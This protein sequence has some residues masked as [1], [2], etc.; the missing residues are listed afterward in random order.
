M[1]C[2]LKTWQ[3]YSPKPKYPTQGLR[4][5][6]APKEFE[7]E[8]SELKKNWDKKPVNA[9]QV[10]NRYNDRDRDSDD[11]RDVR[12]EYEP[13]NGNAIAK[14]NTRLNEE[15]INRNRV[16]NYN[17][18]QDSYERLPVR[19]ADSW[20]ELPERDPSGRPANEGEEDYDD[21][22][23]AE[24][25]TLRPVKVPAVV[26]HVYG[27]PPPLESGKPT[28]PPRYLKAMS[29][30]PSTSGSIASPEKYTREVYENSRD[31]YQGRL[32]SGNIPTLRELLPTPDD[33]G[34]TYKTEPMVNHKYVN[35]GD[36]YRKATSE[37]AEPEEEPLPVD[38]NDGPLAGYAKDQYDKQL[39]ST[40]TK[41][42]ASSKNRSPMNIG[43]LSGG[44]ESAQ[45]IQPIKPA[46]RPIS[47]YFSSSPSNGQNSQ[48]SK[49]SIPYTS[50]SQTS[51]QTQSKIPESVLPPLS[52]SSVRSSSVPSS[53]S[54]SSEY[55]SP[56]RGDQQVVPLQPGQVPLLP[57][58]SR[59]PVSLD[60]GFDSG[61]RPLSAYSVF[62]AAADNGQSAAKESSYQPQ[63][64]KTYVVSNSRQQT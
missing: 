8:K 31:V 42:M 20:R 48:S 16:N 46:I 10:N 60:L 30:I 56:I 54:Q 17:Q 53:G 35:L 49:S 24:L 5:I 14:L 23:G 63:S 61:T 51:S 22:R 57:E 9:I 11:D 29:D 4:V 38:D 21:E 40:L 50:Q 58:V 6:P 43:G 44:S 15:R 19:Q 52:Y 64:M 26:R 34:V 45:P 62:N 27:A 59:K 28:I 2:G 36:V 7:Y 37:A 41:L 32:T 47:S 12:D 3:D 33:Q 18:N 13:N 55:L 39:I 1:C 25:P